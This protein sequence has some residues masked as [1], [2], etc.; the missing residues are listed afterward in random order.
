MALAKSMNLDSAKGAL[1]QQVVKDGP[2][3]AAGLQK[4]DVI[5][6]FDGQPI[7]DASMLQDK[8]ANA[9]HWNRGGSDRGCAI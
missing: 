1:V 3:E 6:A 2:A 4:N 9:G 7:T 8:V 5:I